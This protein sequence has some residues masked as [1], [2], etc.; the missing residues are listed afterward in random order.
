MNKLSVSQISTLRWDLEADVHAYYERGFRGIGLYRPKVEDFGVERAAELLAE[1]S[2][3]ATSLSW[4][5]GFTGSDGRTFEDAVSDAIA[6][7]IQAAEL[8]AETVIILAGGKNN[9]IKNHLRRVLYQALCR[10]AAV[11]SE[12]GVKV[13]IEPFHPGCGEEWS[14][15]NDFDATLDIIERVDNPALGLV[16]DTYHLGMECDIAHAVADIVPHLHLVQLGDGRHCPHGEMNRCL[17]GDGRV[18][19]TDLMDLLFRNGYQGPLEVELIGE[20]VEH[21][22]YDSL[23]DH[24]RAYLSHAL[25]LHC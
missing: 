2:M 20:D 19:L 12:H 9:H 6:A 22:G 18:P 3:A 8:G 16:L 14:F 23:L 24:T 15:V 4:A 13:A 21:L 17:L 7:V 11:A 10:I 5:G 25:P 1:Y